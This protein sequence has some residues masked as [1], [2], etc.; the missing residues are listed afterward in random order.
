MGSIVSSGVG[1]G[2][3][4]A[5]LVKSLVQAEGA[6][7][8]ARLDAEEAKVQAKLSALGTLRSALASVPR[9]GHD[10]EEHRQISR[11]PGNAVGARLHRGDRHGST[12][13]PG[14]L[15]DRGRAARRGAQASVGPRSL[16]AARRCRSVI[17]TLHIATRR[18][19][20]RRRHRLD[21]TT[22][23]PASRPRSTPPRRAPRCTRPILTGAGEARLTHHGAH[24]R[25][26][27]RDDDHAKR[28]RRRFGGPRLSAVRGGLTQVQAA[29]DARAVIDGLTV[30]STTN[31]FSG[32]IAGVD[33]TLK[34][35]Q[36]R[37]TRRRK[38]RSA[39]TERPLARRSISS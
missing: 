27:Q 9:H 32:A 34:R 22:R 26:G 14:Q 23:W 29:L 19:E 3:D 31:T 24:R 18:P 11:A 25:R 1:S 30:T 21:A 15:S 2:L 8:T 36:R 28:R 6:P 33:V 4:A 20:F 17:G 35:S 38:L 16:R 5:S 10:A 37:R 7:K 39:T 13:V 12:A